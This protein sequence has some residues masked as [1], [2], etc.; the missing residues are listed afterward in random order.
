MPIPTSQQ[1]R[2]ALSKDLNISGAKPPTKVLDDAMRKT[3][4][5]NKDG[6]I[7]EFAHRQAD[8]DFWNGVKYYG[9]GTRSRVR[10]RRTQIESLEPVEVKAVTK[11]KT[12]AVAL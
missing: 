10:I 11:R 3:F 12:K 9:S 8:K 1:M 7:L 2:I 6:A 5:A 4:T